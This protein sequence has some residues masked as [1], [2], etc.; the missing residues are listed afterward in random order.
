VKIQEVVRIGSVESE[1][2]SNLLRGESFVC[3]VILMNM[4]FHLVAIFTFLDVSQA[5]NK[6]KKF[7]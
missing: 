4:V 6:L 7:V 2:T 3:H 1:G 5:A